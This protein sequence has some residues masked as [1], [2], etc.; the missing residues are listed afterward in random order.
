M[1]LDQ[2]C[3]LPELPKPHYSFPM[4]L[5]LLATV[6]PFLVEYVRITHSVGIGPMHTERHVK[7]A[8]AV[9]REVNARSPK[10]PAALAVNYSPYHKFGPAADDFGRLYEK[11][12]AAL[13]QSMADISRWISEFNAGGTPVH[14]EAVLLD[15]ERYDFRASN[16]P[17]LNAAI[18]RKY[19]EVY[20]RAK[21]YF[22]SAL[23]EWYR[24]GAMQKAARP[25][26]SWTPY[27]RFNGQERGD[28][29]SCSLYRITQPES[30]LEILERTGKHAAE[31]HLP[32]NVWLALGAGWR[33]DTSLRSKEYFD[34]NWDYDEGYSRRMGYELN[35][36]PEVPR[37][38][39]FYP[40]AFDPRV[41]SWGRHFAA[42]VNGA[43]EIRPSTP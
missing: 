13:E 40:A 39:I 15:C 9:C 2:I 10:I 21:Q 17:E 43:A 23:V 5:D 35:R 30:D 32:V 37:A 4:R 31:H 22:P 27:L 8:L 18:V 11:E 25:P 7:S 33:Q 38:V 3:A 14:V 19:D 20:W 26:G 41:K 16:T 36:R 28:A 34:L 1:T 12:I 29:F 24:R 6:D 42:Y